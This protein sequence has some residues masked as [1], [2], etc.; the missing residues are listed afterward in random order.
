MTEK[1]INKANYLLFV[2]LIFAALLAASLI[3]ARIS[4]GD[5][6]SDANTMISGENFSQYGWRGSLAIPYYT[7]RGNYS[8]CAEGAG[9][10]EGSVSCADTH[11][12]GFPYWVNG[13]LQN[14]FPNALALFRLVAILISSA[15]ILLWPS[16]FRKLGADQTTAFAAA[17]AILVHPDFLTYADSL[18]HIPWA[19]FFLTVFCHQWLIFLEQNRSSALV[20]SFLSFFLN[21]WTSF[22]NFAWIPIFAALICWHKGLVKKRFIAWVAVGALP[23]MTLILRLYH[24]SLLLGDWSLAIKDLLGA[25]SQRSDVGWGRVL[26]NLQKRMGEFFLPLLPL[27]IRLVI[28]A[29]RGRSLLSETKS[30]L[31]MALLLMI[32]PTAWVLL[33]RQHFVVHGHPVVWF[34]PAY[35]L[36]AGGLLLSLK[37]ERRI[38]ARFLLGTTLTLMLARFLL[39]PQ[40]N[41]WVPLSSRLAEHI[42]Q[43]EFALDRIKALGKESEPYVRFSVPTEAPQIAYQLQRDFRFFTQGQ[44]CREVNRTY[45]LVVKDSLDQDVERCEARKGKTSEF[46]GLRVYFPEEGK[47]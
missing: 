37:T 22:E 15:T 21:T 41:R 36:L 27:L 47:I 34:L 45:I 11:Y 17:L 20:L 25:A 40:W 28:N 5:H 3:K 2:C 26:Y 24:H 7:F 35:G 10:V 31:Q 33:M 4:Y 18:H 12:P 32:P 9:S 43:S 23:V 46:M 39:V 30:I 42:A 13:V 19:L 14:F 16:V 1:Y 44:A 8:R 38:M 6:F 29:F